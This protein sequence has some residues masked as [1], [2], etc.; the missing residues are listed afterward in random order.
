M[1]GEVLFQREDRT[2][3][4]PRQG[5]VTKLSGGEECSGSHMY[6]CH[7]AK[8]HYPPLTRRKRPMQPVQSRTCKIF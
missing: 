1:R 3:P 5:T 7:M 4:R 2:A 8:S 6:V